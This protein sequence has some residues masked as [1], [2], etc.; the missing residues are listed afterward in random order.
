MFLWLNI[1]PAVGQTASKYFV[2]KQSYLTASFSGL[3]SAKQ[4][5]IIPLSPTMLDSQYEVFIVIGC[6]VFTKHVA[7]HDDPTSSPWTHR[8]K[9]YHSE[10][11]V[12]YLV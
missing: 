1:L 12:I 2:I 9:R 10:A 4:A 11:F 6:L 3:V 8:S 5:Q 7:V